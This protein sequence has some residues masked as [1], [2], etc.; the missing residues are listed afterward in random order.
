[1]QKRAPWFVHIVVGLKS[2]RRK[3]QVTTHLLAWLSQN[4]NMKLRRGS[5]VKLAL[6]RKKTRERQCEVKLPPSKRVLLYRGIA[7]YCNIIQCS[8]HIS[9]LYDLQY[10]NKII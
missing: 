6:K 8:H 5:V 2:R 7:I 9:N 4:S 10:I 1:M 3:N